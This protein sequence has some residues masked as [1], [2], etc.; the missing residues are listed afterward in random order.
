MLGSHVFLNDSGRA[1]KLAHQPN[2]ASD[3]AG[4]SLSCKTFGAVAQLGEH[5]LCK[6]GVAGSIPVRSTCSIVT[7]QRFPLRGFS[8]RGSVLCAILQPTW[9]V[10]GQV[11]L[12][13]TWAKMN[14]KLNEG[15]VTNA[16]EAVDLTGFD[17]ENVA[18]ASLEFLYVDVPEAAAFPHELDFIVRMTMGRRTTPREGAEKKHGDI[19]VAVIGPNE[20]VRTTLK[21][22]VLLTNPVHPTDAPVVGVLRQARAA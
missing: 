12:Y 19:H 22:Q 15:R 4:K 17:D 2:D 18:F 3:R 1:Q 21:G 14:I 9:R 20:L 6:Q 8:F 16:T 5:L 13:E 7:L 10:L 11:L